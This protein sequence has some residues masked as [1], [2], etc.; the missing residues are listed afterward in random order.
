MDKNKF[1]EFAKDVISDKEYPEAGDVLKLVEGDVITDNH[2]RRLVDPSIFKI[3]GKTLNVWVGQS[4]PVM[5]PEDE[6]M[7]RGMSG[8]IWK[9]FQDYV[10][11]N[12]GT[13]PPKTITIDSIP[14]DVREKAKHDAVLYGDSFI[15][16][17]R[18]SDL[19]DIWIDGI[20]DPKIDE[21]VVLEGITQSFKMNLKLAKLKKELDDLQKLRAIVEEHDIESFMKMRHMSDTIENRAMVSRFL[22]YLGL[23]MNLSHPHI[24]NRFGNMV[25]FPSRCN[26]KRWF[27]SH[28]DEITKSISITSTGGILW[29]PETSVNL[30]SVI[31]MTWPAFDSST[32][33]ISGTWSGVLPTCIDLSPI[34]RISLGTL[35]MIGPDLNSG[36]GL[37]APNLNNSEK[38]ALE[39]V[40]KKGR[41]KK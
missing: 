13:I 22:W 12:T 15:M 24:L 41:R 39:R 2:N 5:M 19:Y 7:M 20:R 4:Y 8:E 9:K 14:E 31:Y 28:I 16:T 37:S 33:K 18:R 23:S 17:V 40:I 32:F 38:K 6:K 1:N 3:H 11:S 10:E 29:K 27:A 35:S 34:E 21:P 36:Y 30:A 26:G 25:Y